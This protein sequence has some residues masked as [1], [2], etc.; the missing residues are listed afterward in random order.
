MSR[1]YGFSGSAA[2]SFVTQ[3]GTGTGDTELVA[4]PGAGRKLAV[5]SLTVTITTAAAQAFDIEDDGSTPVEI[6]KAPA[7]LAAGTYAVDA[8]PLG[9][10]LTAN[11]ALQF[12]TA[13]AGVGATISGFGYILESA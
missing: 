6:F 8:G 7:S 2:F 13:A 1:A 9:I 10:A 12:D 5:Q 11:T 4:A 3:I